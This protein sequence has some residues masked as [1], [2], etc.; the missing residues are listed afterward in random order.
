MTE[1]KNLFIPLKSEHYEAFKR[2]EKTIEYRQYGARWNEKTCPIGRGATLSKGYGKQN[3]LSG[4]VDGF[5]RIKLKDAP[6]NVA[7]IYPDCE[8]DIAAIGIDIPTTRDDS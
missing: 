6:A 2:G 3:R 1:M 8:R 5:N 4:V 7:N